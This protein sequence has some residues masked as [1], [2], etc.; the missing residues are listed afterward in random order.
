MDDLISRIKLEQKSH[1]KL[2]E[3]IAMTFFSTSDDV[4]QS[5]TG[6]NGHFVQFLLLIDVLLRMKSVESDKK[7]LISRFKK[8]YQDE[9]DKSTID[10]FEI[11]YSSENALWWYS[12]DS[13]LY[14]MLNKALRTQDIDTLFLFRFFIRDIYE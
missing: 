7:E 4:D 9:E 1:G 6:L 8:I 3:P 14:G 13:F 2:N 12:R 10:E 11:D 5:T